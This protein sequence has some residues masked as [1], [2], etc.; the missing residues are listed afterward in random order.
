MKGRLLVIG[1]ASLAPGI[2]DGLV[3]DRPHRLEDPRRHVFAFCSADGKVGILFQQPRSVHLRHV[4]LVR[5]V[6]PN[7]DRLH[8]SSAT[9]RDEFDLDAK[10]LDGVGDAPKQMHLERVEEENGDDA[11]WCGCD[12]GSEDMLHPMEH[13]LFVEPRLLLDGI[14]S[15]LGMLGQL[16]LVDRPPLDT[17]VHDEGCEK[18]T[19]SCHRQRDGAAFTFFGSLSHVDSSLPA[20]IDGRLWR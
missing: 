1:V 12:V 6:D 9:A 15:A 10:T 13:H 4:G 14:D 5:L 16:A 18:P 19:S 11:D 20:N 8:E 17:L 7:V 2:P 3:R